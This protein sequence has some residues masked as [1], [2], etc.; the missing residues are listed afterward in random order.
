LST[1]QNVLFGFPVLL[2]SVIAQEYAHGYAALKQGDPTAQQLGRLTWNPVKHIDPFMTILLPLVLLAASGGKMA[3]GGAKPVPV[4]P[5]NY[6]HPRRGDIIVSLAGVFTN[7]LI[8]LACT[9][10][11]AAVGFIGQYVPGIGE[12][13]GILQVMFYFGVWINFMLIAFNL[14]PIP[15]L[16]GSHVVKYLL[17][18]SW[19]LRYEQ[20]GRYGIIV[21][22]L[23]LYGGGR[24]LQVWMSPA[25][26]VASRLLARV[27]P[28]VLPSADQWLR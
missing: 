10:L 19:A 1:L 13:L 7:L 23:L 27:Q 15:P 4:D 12:T 28:L 25:A 18:A 21:L 22:V 8:A 26:S 14:I 5:R 2:V 11:I 3:L 9:I 20:F 6:K 24:V 17:P 16:D